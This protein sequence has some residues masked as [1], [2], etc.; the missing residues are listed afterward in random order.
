MKFLQAILALLRRNKRPAPATEAAQAAAAPA[1]R[2]PAGG[3]RKP[4]PQLLDKEAIRALPDFSGL[5]LDAIEVLS[6]PAAIAA[7][8]AALRQAGPLGFDTESKPTFNKGEHAQGP[9]LIQLATATRAYLFPL[10]QGALPAPLAQ[11]LAAPEVRKIGFDLRSDLV[12]LA[13]NHGVHCQGVDD[14]VSHF[15]RRGYAHTV[16]AVQAVGLLFGQHYRKSKSAKMS[17]WASTELSISQRRYAANDAYV[18]LRVYLA[19]A[20]KH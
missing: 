4:R 7:A 3:G 5:P 11:L 1:A 12:M 20:A 16:G 2:R 14:L 17:N 15:K 8:C 19:L 18:A 13:G 9:H 6:E 10:G